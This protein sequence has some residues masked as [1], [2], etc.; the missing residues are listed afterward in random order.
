MSLLFHFFFPVWYALFSISTEKFP[1]ENG[2]PTV[3][4][5]NK[6]TSAGDH[7]KIATQEENE[8]SRRSFSDVDVDDEGWCESFAYTKM[9][10]R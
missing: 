10:S 9:P 8:S 1:A 7:K 3:K 6:Q 5:K 2:R 4:W